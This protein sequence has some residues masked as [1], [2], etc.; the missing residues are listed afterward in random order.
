M[1]PN[2]FVNTVLIRHDRHYLKAAGI[3]PPTKL[4]IS[5]EVQNIP[6]F[7]TGCSQAAIN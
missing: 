5:A 7:H 4:S 1:C 3:Y 6:R 2:V